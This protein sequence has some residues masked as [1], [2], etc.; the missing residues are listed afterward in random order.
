MYDWKRELSE[1]R[2][3][4]EKNNIFQIWKWNHESACT[5][6]KSNKHHI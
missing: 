3:E 1:F 4:W 2:Q 6:T 5:H